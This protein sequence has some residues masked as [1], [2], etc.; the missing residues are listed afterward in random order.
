MAQPVDG[1]LAAESRGKWRPFL[2]TVLVLTATL[3]LVALAAVEGFWYGYR[4][5]M[6]TVSRVA[7]DSPVAP[8]GL[9][10]GGLV[11]ALTAVVLLAAA[12]GLLGLVAMLVRH[13]RNAR[14]ASR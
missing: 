7:M 4:A 13:R 10:M 3:A 5:S 1:V 11:G 9:V 2:L 6:D 8:A 12:L 14:T